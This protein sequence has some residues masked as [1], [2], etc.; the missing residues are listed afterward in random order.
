[1]KQSFAKYK[2]GIL[3]FGLLFAACANS[4]PS[5]A[6]PSNN[7]NI[8]TGA[9]PPPLPVAQKLEDGVVVHRVRL[10]GGDEASDVWIYLPEKTN[11]QKLPVVLVTAAGSYLWNGTS[12]DEGD[13]PEH[14]PYVRKG[15]AVIAYETPGSLDKVDLKNISDEQLLKAVTDFKNSKAGLVSEQN[16]LNYALEKVAALDS[17]RIYIAGHSSAA[18]HALLVAANEPRV[19]AAIAYAPATDLEKRLAKIIPEFNSDVPG[20]EG[21]IKT[22]SPKNN[23]SQIKVPVFIFHAADDSVIPIE[24]TKTFT[25][26]LRK[27]NS[28]VTF[29]TADKGDHYDSMIE[30]GIPNA[31]KWLNKIAI[32]AKA[33]K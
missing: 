6:Q 11:G 33:G 4:Q 25:A 19:E 3:V 30:Q 14:L 21:F 24:D 9:N 20:F 13:M 26:E 7:K 28:N 10:N 8:Q 29:E 15:Y 27:V 5:N 2:F 12:L 17:E 1:M 32:A 23:I 31:I 18:T 16:A 22:S